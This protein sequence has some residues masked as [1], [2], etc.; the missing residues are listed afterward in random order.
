MTTSQQSA[1]RA[2]L[3]AEKAWLKAYGWSEV[4]PGR[5]THKSAPN[6]AAAIS[7]RDAIAFTRSDPLKYG[8]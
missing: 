3:A 5:W 6:V 7:L 2:L 4:M 1:T 8:T